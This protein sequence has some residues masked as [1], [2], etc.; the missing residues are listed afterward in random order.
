MRKGAI[1]TTLLAVINA[2]VAVKMLTGNG[3][4][5]YHPTSA[6]VAQQ[7]PHQLPSVKTILNRMGN[8]VAR[9][10]IRPVTPWDKVEVE[11]KEEM[12]PIQKMAEKWKKVAIQI[13]EKDREEYNMGVWG[14]TIYVEQKNIKKGEVV[15]IHHQLLSTSQLVKMS[16]TAP[17]SSPQSAT[18]TSSPTIKSTEI[19]IANREL[20]IPLAQSSSTTTTISSSS[21]T[22]TSIPKVPAESSI[23]KSPPSIES[24]PPSPPPEMTIFR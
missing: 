4:K 12:G 17:P 10:I 22:T 16:P 20:E 3:K 15:A 2:L 6:P 7:T 14:D 13:P 24:T 8:K 9:G 21:S 5:E 1:V 11:T 18:S 19:R 23:S